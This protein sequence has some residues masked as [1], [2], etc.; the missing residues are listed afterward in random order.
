MERFFS[1]NHGPPTDCY[2]IIQK[3]DWQISLAEYLYEN[4]P[5]TEM[6][7]CLK[8]ANKHVHVYCFHGKHFTRWDLR[9]M[10][11]T[12]NFVQKDSEET[13]PSL[14]TLLMYD[15]ANSTRRNTS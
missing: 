11:E 12:D 10:F 6:P 7:S 8:V 9:G 1:F 2:L 15:V 3:L 5:L 4:I 13:L 14:E